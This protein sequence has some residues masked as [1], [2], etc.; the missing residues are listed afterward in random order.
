MSYNTVIGARYVAGPYR[1]DALREM[2]M[3][4][5]NVHDKASVRVRQQRERMKR[6]EQAKAELA[7]RRAASGR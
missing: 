5:E 2:R 7:A 1:D 6:Y 4:A 3:H